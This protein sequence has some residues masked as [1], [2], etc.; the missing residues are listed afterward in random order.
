MTLTQTGATF[1]V[2]HPPGCCCQACKTRRR[3]IE[4][5]ALLDIQKVHHADPAIERTRRTSWPI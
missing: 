1:N 5:L 4:S 3:I 2:D